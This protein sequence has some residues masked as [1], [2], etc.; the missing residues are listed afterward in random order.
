MTKTT[1]TTTTTK[2]NC[3]GPVFGKLTVGCP[4]CDELAA[5]A[6]PVS[7]SWRRPSGPSLSDEIRAHTCTRSHC[8][9]VCTFGDW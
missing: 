2:H 6:E 1:T 5:G 8:G 9:I 4:R 7:Q 3:G